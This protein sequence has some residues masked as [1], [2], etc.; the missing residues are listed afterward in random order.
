MI[1]YGD[2]VRINKGFFEGCEGMAVNYSRN[3]GKYEIEVKKFIEERTIA[4]VRNVFIEKTIV[5]SEGYVTKLGKK[6]DK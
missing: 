5:V 2:P 1:K 6:E 3:T 4:G